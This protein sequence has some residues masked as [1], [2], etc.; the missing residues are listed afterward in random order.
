[1]VSLNHNVRELLSISLTMT[2]VVGYAIH[3]SL[4]SRVSARMGPR[5]RLRKIGELVME[6][7]REVFVVH[8]SLVDVMQLA[9]PWLRFI[10]SVTVMTDFGLEQLLR[11]IGEEADEG[12][13]EGNVGT[14]GSGEHDVV[15]SRSGIGVVCGSAAP[16]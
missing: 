16:E 4:G 1:M 8:P 6:D 7:T 11:K 12:V 14:H 3:P 15:G 13:G 10:P 2:Q 5:L 9:Y